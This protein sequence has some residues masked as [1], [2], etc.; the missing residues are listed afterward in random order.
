MIQWKFAN[1]S[2]NYSEYCRL[3]EEAPRYEIIKGVGYLIPSPGARH[4][5][6]SANLGFFLYQYVRS[7]GLSE[8][9][10]APY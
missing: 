10:F 1:R 2:T 3:L 4:Q 6:V 7:R 5:M 9:Y 8:V